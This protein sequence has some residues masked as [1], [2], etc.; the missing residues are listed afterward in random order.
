M[1]ITSATERRS[2]PWA[3]WLLVCAVVLAVT[4]GYW[5]FAWWRTPD[6]DFGLIV[7]NRYDDMSCAPLIQALA[8]GRIGESLTYEHLGQ[9]VQLFLI[10]ALAIHAICVRFFGL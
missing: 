10:A 5:V 8:Q 2:S 3:W 9:G 7:I 6:A 1:A 4:G